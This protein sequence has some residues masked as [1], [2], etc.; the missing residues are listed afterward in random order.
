MCPVGDKCP[1]LRGGRG[2][3]GKSGIE[4]GFHLCAMEILQRPFARRG[5][6]CQEDLMLVYTVLA[7]I[8]QRAGEPLTQL[9]F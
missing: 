2:G 6:T 4:K 8:W 1:P 5:L 3:G 9:A 7:E